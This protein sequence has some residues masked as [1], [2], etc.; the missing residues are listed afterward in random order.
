MSILVH[1]TSLIVPATFEDIEESVS[2]S[3]GKKCKPKKVDPAML[4]WVL[5]PDEK[6]TENSPKK[7]PKAE[8]K[9]TE[10][11]ISLPSLEE[12]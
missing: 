2:I 11:T 12:T 5:G 3:N 9:R 6:A 7:S 1:D 8:I 10:P 4:T